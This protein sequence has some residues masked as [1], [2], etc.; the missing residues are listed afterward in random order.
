VC[1]DFNIDRGSSLFGGFGRTWP[2]TDVDHAPGAR[3]PA[4]PG[5]GLRR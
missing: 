5:T 3:L 4:A 1:G 2:V